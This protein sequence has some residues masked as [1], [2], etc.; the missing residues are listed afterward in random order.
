MNEALR[1][2]ETLLSGSA[3]TPPRFP[4]NSR[5][6]GVP[7]LTRTERDGRTV[8]YLARRFIPPPED[9]TLAFVHTAVQ[10]DRLDLLASTY[11][12]DPEQWWKIPD[13]N[14]AM[15]PD[16]LTDTPGRKLRIALPDRFTGPT[17]VA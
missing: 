15:Q 13:A 1:R 14:G 16:A 5:Y 3:A 9:F 6:F 11:L 4:A 10:G 12:G 17:G 8:A 2:L 7:T